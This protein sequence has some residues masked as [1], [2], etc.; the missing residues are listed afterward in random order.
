[1]YTSIDVLIAFETANNIRNN[2][3]EGSISILKF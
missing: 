2:I 1:M 3:V